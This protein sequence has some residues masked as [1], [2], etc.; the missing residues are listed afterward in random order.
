MSEDVKNAR[1]I[2]FAN[3]KGGVGKT[4]TVI[5]LGVSLASDGYKVLLV[6]MD[7]QG[8]IAKGL[9]KGLTLNK[10]TMSEFI[11]KPGVYEDVVVHYSDSLSIL[12]SNR[13]LADVEKVLQGLKEGVREV[14]LR[15]RLNKL[16]GLFDF[17]LIDCPPSLGY[18]TINGLVASTDIIIPTM[19]EYL[20]YEGCIEVRETV[21]HIVKKFNP[22]TDIRAVVGNRIRNININKAILELIDAK[23]HAMM[24]DTHIRQDAKIGEAQLIGKSVI[25]YKPYSAGSQDFASLKKELID[26]CK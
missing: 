21:N 16:L 14:V 13:S 2:A 23:L 25:D 20:S 4:T 1:V 10:M 9:R 24:L 12:P 6:D 22:E 11:V 3:Q 19:A 15:S 5:N 7:P 26:V 18:L 17:I 8:H